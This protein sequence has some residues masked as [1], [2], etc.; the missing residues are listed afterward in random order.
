[1]IKSF[2]T[3]YKKNTQGGLEE[4]SIH[5]VQE[6]GMHPRIVT[7]FGELEGKTQVTEDV[8]K[9]GKNVGKKNE[10]TPWT[11]ALAEAQSKWEKKVKTGYVKK[12]EDAK[13]GKI[14]SS[15]IKGGIAPMLAHSY[16]DHGT[17]MAFPC[18]GQPKLDGI[19]CLAIKSG[20]SV[21]LWSR[22]RKEIT[23]C[24]H[25]IDAINAAY[26]CDIILDGELYTHD[27]KND[28]EKIISAVRKDKPSPEALK[29]QYHIYDRADV[30]WGFHERFQSI[31]DLNQDPL[32]S[33]L[34]LVDTLPV[35]GVDDVTNKF[36]M[37]S[38]QGYE[39]LMLRNPDSKYENKRSYHL[40]KVKEFQ[41]E[42]FKIVDVEE[43]RGKLQGLVGAFTCVTKE[44]KYFSVKPMGNQEESRKYILDPDLAVGRFLTVKYQNKTAEGIPRFPVGLRFR[45]EL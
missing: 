37:F 14:D 27:Y 44:G 1:M 34:Y 17:K 28:F 26:D 6:E 25:I 11:Q 3:L 10:T 31:F 23:S 39:G 20:P 2:E 36:S 32:S 40:M 12:I 24:P 41:D 18:L 7:H 45:E 21:S 38:S 9:E 35:M 29:V 19:R 22:T 13:A 5:V 16:A 30:P 43:G 8:I 42:E 15:F 4:W 33:V